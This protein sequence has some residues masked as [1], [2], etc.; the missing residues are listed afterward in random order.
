MPELFTNAG[1]STL[2]GGINNSVTSLTVT[3]AATFPATGNF[4]IIIDTELLLVT[5]VAGAVFTVTRGVEGT[6]ANS[7][8]NAAPVTLVLTAASLDNAIDERIAD[9][10]TA[11]A[12]VFGTPSTVGTANAAGAGTQFARDTHIHDGL[13]LPRAL[14][15]AVAATRYVGGTASV[16]PTTGTF[17]LGDYVITQS[18]AI[19]ICTTAGSPGTWTAVSGGGGGAPTTAPYVT[20]AADAGLS[21]EVV[22]GTGVIMTG[23]GAP[24]AASTAGRLYFQTSNNILYR[25]TGAAWTEVGN[26]HAQSHADADHSGA[27]KFDTSVG[28]SLIGTR[29]K[30]NLINGTGV[31]MTGADNA[32]SNRVDVTVNSSAGGSTFV[33]KTSTQS[34]TSSTAL[35]DCTDMQFTTVASTNYLIRFCVY[36]DGDTAGDINFDWTHTGTTTALNWGMVGLGIGATSTTNS[37]KLNNVSG[38]GTAS[39]YGLAGAGTTVYIPGEAFLRVG[40][41]GG[42]MKLRFAQRV[43]SATATRVFLDSYLTYIAV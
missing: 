8:A 24:P 39:E 36:A 34:V 23:A 21:A 43:S 31:T 28:G 38:S 3:S 29:P 6:T 2:N 40:G 33:R 35:V 10:T 4:R 14:T 25:D 19:Y 32:G 16:A 22:L 15:G 37:P 1:A 5:N 9:H 26:D 18:G 20:T 27:N 42:T 12:P 7:H 17:A 13:G 30:I 41:S 11:T